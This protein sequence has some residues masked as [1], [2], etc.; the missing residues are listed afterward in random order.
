VVQVACAI[1]VIA[2]TGLAIEARLASTTA[3]WI[4]HNHSLAQIFIKL[5]RALPALHE[6]GRLREVI[7]FAFAWL[8]AWKDGVLRVE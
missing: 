2:I 3:S 4:L 8:L 5:Q 1:F 6:F 7:T